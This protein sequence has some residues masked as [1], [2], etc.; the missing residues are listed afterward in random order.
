MYKPEKN[1]KQGEDKKS[2]K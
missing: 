2:E 1:H